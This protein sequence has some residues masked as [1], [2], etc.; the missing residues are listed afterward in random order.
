MKNIVHLLFLL[1]FTLNT[2]AQS[3]DSIDSKRK[4]SNNQPEDIIVLVD[5]ESKEIE[6]EPEVYSVIYAAP[7]FPTGEKEM[8]QY[9]EKNLV[10]PESALKNNTLGKCF[11]KFTVLEN[12]D[13]RDITILKGIPNCIECDIE[14]KKLLENMPFWIPGRRPDGKI[15]KVYCV[16]AINFELK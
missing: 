14:A 12:G 10:I 16:L 8:Y 6:P 9:I 15:V 4:G 7:K 2:I 3:K 13:L 5:D 11:L 1:F